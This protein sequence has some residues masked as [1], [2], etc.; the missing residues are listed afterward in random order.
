MSKKMESVINTSLEVLEIYASRI[1]E[2]AKENTE[3]STDMEKNLRILNVIGCDM[4]RLQRLQLKQF[5]S[6]FED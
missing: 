4:E 1:L 5:S 2:K 6:Y 3:D